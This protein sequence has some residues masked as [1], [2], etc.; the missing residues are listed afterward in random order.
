MKS[1]RIQIVSSRQ[2]EGADQYRS[3]QADAPSPGLSIEQ[4]V[5]PAVDA[6]HMPASTGDW[7]FEHQVVPA[8]ILDA[9]GKHRSGC[10][11]REQVDWVAHELPSGHH[12]ALVEA[13][14]PVMTI[15]EG[16]VEQYEEQRGFGHDCIVTRSVLIPH[17]AW[18]RIPGN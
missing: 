8:M 3:F 12:P 15:L 2:I 4:R 5:G 9:T 18:D 13:K 10:A 14:I 1:P 17:E 7:P 6:A 16:V 11:R